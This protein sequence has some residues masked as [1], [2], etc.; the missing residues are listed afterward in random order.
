MRAW[1]LAMFVVAQA[2]IAPL[3]YDHTLNLFETT[4]VAGHVHV[5]VVA[6][7]HGG[8]SAVQVAEPDADH[9]H[10]MLDLHDQCCALHTLAGPLPQSSMAAPIE[11]VGDALPP[12][13]AILIALGDPA[14]LDRPPR[15]L[16]V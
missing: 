12:S 1:L 4:P 8:T 7:H 16:P 5:H 15:P 13:G 10:G 9:H 14:R 2:G 3:I 11:R 6:T